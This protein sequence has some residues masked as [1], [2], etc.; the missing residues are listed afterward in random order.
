[1]SGLI[2]QDDNLKYENNT[3]MIKAWKLE[4]FTI[5]INKNILTYRIP[6]KLWIKY[7]FSIEKFG[8]KV[9]DSREINEKSL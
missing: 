3:L 2:D 4:D 6:L 9:S 1:M 5:S 7:N 8:F